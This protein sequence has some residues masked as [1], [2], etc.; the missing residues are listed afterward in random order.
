LS[1]LDRL[2]IQL[3]SG[4]KFPPLEAQL[5]TLSQL[6]YANVEP[7]GGLLAGAEELKAGLAR[8]RLRAPSTH[9]GLPALKEDLDGFARQAR[10]LGV[11]LVVIPAI[12]PEERGKDA[13]GWRAFGR[14]LGDLAARLEAHG[15]ELAWHNHDFE[16]RKLADGSYPL[17]RIF[18]AAP[19]LKWQA[20]IGWIH[21]AGEDPSHWLRKYRER[22]VALHIKDAAAKGEKLDEDGWTDVG[23]GVIDWTKLLPD[24]R[25][26]DARL[27]V[28]EHDNPKDFEGFAR[29]SRAAMAAW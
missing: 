18:E 11:S 13:A 12:P 10:G 16:F 7:Y 8:H 4:R 5:A 6:G 17:D 14:E 2:S 22:I 1:I 3:Y 21:A 26:T 25:A 9:V 28:L 24:I 15:L 19:N 29:R 20:D 27:L 23:A